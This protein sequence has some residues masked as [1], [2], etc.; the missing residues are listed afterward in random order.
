MYLSVYKL[1]KNKFN[2]DLAKTNFMIFL[3]LR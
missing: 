3:Q 1:V 2:C